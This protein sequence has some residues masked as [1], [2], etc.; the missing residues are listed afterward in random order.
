LFKS[1]LLFWTLELLL[2]GILIYVSTKIAFLFNP[3][4]T[5]VSTLFFPVVISGFLFYLLKPVVTFLIK[6]KIPKIMAILIIYLVFIGLIGLLIGTGV[7]SL[8]KQINHFAEE[9][10]VYL[11]QIDEFINNLMRSRWFKWTIEQDYINVKNIVNTVQNFVMEIP[12]ALTHRLSSILGMVKNI[13]VVIVLVPFILFFMLKDGEK[14]P[15]TIL[16]FVPRSYHAPSL[17]VLKETSTTLATYIQGQLLVCMFVGVA[18]FIGYLLIGLPYAFLFALISAMTNII[19]Y[20]G[21]FIGLA[22]AF[23]FALIY[24]PLQAVLVII[25]VI[26]VQQ[27][28]STVLSPLVIGKKLNTHPVTI[29]TLL[30]VSGNI[31]GIVGMILAIPTYSVVKTIILNITAFIKLQKIKVNNG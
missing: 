28:E 19:P 1:K 20:A 2:I 13:T 17:K 9:L 11:K 4:V 14:L 22:P 7:P 15:G 27:L 18:S 23:F 5:F 24:S 12:T 25:I 8:F 10:P 6:R 30:L 16:R 29:I 21:P 3:I 26:I 31:A